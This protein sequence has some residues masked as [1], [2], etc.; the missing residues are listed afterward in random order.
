M[1]GEVFVR[2]RIDERRSLSA[3]SLRTLSRA[4]HRLGQREQREC[5]RGQGRVS[6]P[7]RR[8]HCTLGA[9]VHLFVSCSP[10]EI[11]GKL[12]HECHGLGR[13]LVRKALDRARKARAGLLV[14]SEQTLDG[15]APARDCRVVGSD[16]ERFQQGAM[17][18][19]E[20]P[21]RRLCCR[22]REQE[23]DPLGRGRGRG[24]EAKCVGEPVR[25]A[26]RCEPRGTFTRL[27]QNGHC[28][29]VALARGA[30]D[31]VGARRSRRAARCKQFGTA[32]VCA[33]SPTTGRRLVG[34]TA[35]ERMPETKPARHFSA[36]NEVEQEQLVDRFHGGG[37][38]CCGSCCS[39]L[40]LEG[41]AG[42]RR[43]LEHPARIVRQKAELLAERCGDGRRNLDAAERDIRCVPGLA[44]TAERPR[45]LFEI[46]RIAA[47]LFIENAGLLTEEL[48]SFERGQRGEL[49]PDHRPRAIGPFDCG[50]E[51]LC[52]LAWADGQD[53]EDARAGRP[54]EQRAEKL[55]GRRVGPVDVVEYQN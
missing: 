43:S 26:C 2:Q 35:D 6:E 17:T 39:Q 8:A 21:A 4:G 22:T 3:I 36:P 19:G 7:S 32:L 46:K 5:C 1:A 33:Q 53:D 52:H 23:V 38:R 10:D 51:A 13:A 18:V 41:V 29:E 50:R 16:R 11:H 47:A 30:L 44:V 34:G 15:S 40:G 20:V 55:D 9:R 54:P 37:L 27:A 49:D 48:P 24:K 12:V 42:H 28:A 14:P 45:K 25:R 31:V